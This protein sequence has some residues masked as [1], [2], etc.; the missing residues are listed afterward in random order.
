[1][2][3]PQ[4]QFKR[5]TKTKYKRANI[6]LP[7]GLAIEAQKLIDQYHFEGLSELCQ[8]LIREAAF[9]KNR[10]HPPSFL[11]NEDHPQGPEPDG[12]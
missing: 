11:L 8:H 10:S 3:E 5:K 7:P 4:G 1:M 12:N 9:N 6:T 2:K